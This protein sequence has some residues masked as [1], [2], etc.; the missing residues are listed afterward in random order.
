MRSESW[1]I[2]RGVSD[3]AREK[4][5]IYQYPQFKLNNLVPGSNCLTNW[6]RQIS[7]P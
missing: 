6:Y 7:N 2:R 5:V 4:F 3:S 1:R